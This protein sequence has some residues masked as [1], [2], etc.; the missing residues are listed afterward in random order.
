MTEKVDKILA[1]EEPI[2]AQA[3]RAVITADVSGLKRLLGQ[4][5]DLISIRAKAVHRSTLLHYTASNGIED[6]LQL[7]GESIYQLIQNCAPAERPPLQERAIEI[8]WVL[9]DAGAEVD[10]TCET[11]GGGHL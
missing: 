6:E 2:F 10:A 9:L 7:S 8:A 1:A 5:P 4:N 11:Y 3:V